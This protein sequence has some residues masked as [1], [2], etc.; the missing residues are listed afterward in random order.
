MKD[1]IQDDQL[2]LL[3]NNLYTGIIMNGMAYFGI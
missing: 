2:Y 3:N 1:L